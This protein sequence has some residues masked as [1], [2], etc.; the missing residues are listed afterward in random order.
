VAEVFAEEKPR[1]LPLPVHR[2]VAELVRPVRQL[3]GIWVPFDLN[4]YSIPP[5]VVGR[6]SLTLVAS[7]TV[8]RILDG[9]LEI[10][11][12][13]RSYDREEYIDEAGH[14]EALLEHKRRARGQ[15]PCGR[16][17]AAVPETQAFLQAAFTKGEN[18]GATTLKLLRLLDDYGAKALQAAVI[19]A[20]ERDTPRISSVAYLLE[21]RRRAAKTR[22][23]LPVDLKRR[24]DLADLV[25]R[26]HEAEIYDELSRTDDD[27][28]S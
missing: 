27:G 16:L 11:S 14:E 3:K 28:D 21:R 19:E 1:L 23:P 4:H 20:L 8:V 5:E 17:S 24:P 13:R 25:V 22:P 7:A 12:H 26:P 9:Q 15:T 10:V 2:F 18:A 6:R